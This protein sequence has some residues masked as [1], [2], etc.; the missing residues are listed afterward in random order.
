MA[1]HH[2]SRC[3]RSVIAACPR[4]DCIGL[5]Y[6]TEFRL[7]NRA[8]LIASILKPSHAALA[9]L[10]K[11]VRGWKEHAGRQELIVREH[12][13]DVENEQ[14]AFRKHNILE[15]RKSLTRHILER[16]SD[17]AGQFESTKG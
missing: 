7:Q 16:R 12:A 13:G 5:C 17:D 1:I 6:D 4:S 11:G 3:D 15:Q 8:N 10:S 9:M 14:V 2:R